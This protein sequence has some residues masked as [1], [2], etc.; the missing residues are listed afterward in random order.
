MSL[1]RISTR[2]ETPLHKII[3]QKVVIDKYI[4]ED[5]RLHRFPCSLKAAIRQIFSFFSAARKLSI[6]V[7][8]KQCPTPLGL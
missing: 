8:S 3:F 7:L 5:D 2:D 6:L 1:D 4:P